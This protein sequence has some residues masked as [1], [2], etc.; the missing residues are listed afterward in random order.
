M[1][2]LPW[3]G[4][5]AFVIAMLALDLGVFQRKSHV[6]TIKEALTWFGIWF[7][8]AMIFNIGVVVFHERGT[9]AGLEFF[10]GFLVEKSLSID[11]IFVFILIFNYLSIPTVFQH[12]V[13]FWGSN[14]ADV[15]RSIEATV[16]VRITHE[17]KSAAGR[18][19]GT[20]PTPIRP[21]GVGIG[22]NCGVECTVR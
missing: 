19:A 17:R 12:K 18:S 9:V 8:L 21:D 13:L 11:N 14:G 10:T 3:I 6:I 7:G 4:F 20:V 16:A 1:D 15:T 22:G 5:T 2:Y